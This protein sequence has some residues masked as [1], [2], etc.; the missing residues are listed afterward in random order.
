[1]DYTDSS[2]SKSNER[3]NC[4]QQN[5]NS[6][7]RNKMP[8]S[9]LSGVLT[10]LPICCPASQYCKRY[11]YICVHVHTQKNLHACGCADTHTH[12]SGHR[13]FLIRR[14]DF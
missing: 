2:D 10:I 3:Q 9:T 4:P 7:R 6:E 12:T 13:T 14:C 5:L 11:K 1:M 8:R